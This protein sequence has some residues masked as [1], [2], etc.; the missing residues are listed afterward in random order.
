MSTLD[1]NVWISANYR[2]RHVKIFQLWSVGI[3]IYVHFCVFTSCLCILRHETKCHENTWMSG[4]FTNHV[5]IRCLCSESSITRASMIY[6]KCPVDIEFLLHRLTYLIFCGKEDRSEAS[7]YSSSTQG[8]Y[9]SQRTRAPHHRC[10][11]IINQIREA[12]ERKES[13]S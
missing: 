11:N 13:V 2:R 3:Y 10:R 5:D 6:K 4:S 7:H 8:C 1:W 12:A 9:R